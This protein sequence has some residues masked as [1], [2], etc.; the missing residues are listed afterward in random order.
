MDIAYD[1]PGEHHTLFYEKFEYAKGVVRSHKSKDRQY[2]GQKK[3]DNQ[4]S[5]K[6][7]TT[8]GVNSCT[9]EG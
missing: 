2:N 6:H 7:Y 9:P 5:T 4:W 8:P 3:K 1:Y